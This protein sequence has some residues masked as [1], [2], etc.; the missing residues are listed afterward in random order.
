[1]VL[2][3]LHP[4]NADTM[5]WSAYISRF[6]QFVVLNGIA[7]DL[8]VP[9]LISTV[10]DP[11]YG[12]MYN[13]C[14]PTD[15]GTKTLEQLVRLISNYLHPCSNELEN[16]HKFRSRKQKASESITDYLHELKQMANSCYFKSK[17]MENI[18][19]QLVSGLIDKEIQKRIFDKGLRVYQEILDLALMLEAK[20]IAPI[21]KLYDST[22]E[23]SNEG[24]E[25]DTSVLAD[26]PDSL[27]PEH[28]SSI[29][30]AENITLNMFFQHVDN[31]QQSSL[32]QKMDASDV[33]YDLIGVTELKSENTQELEQI[34]ENWTVFRRIHREHRNRTVT[35]AV[36]PGV[37]VTRRTDLESDHGED[38]W[39]SFTSGGRLVYVGLVYVSFNHDDECA[40]RWCEN[41]QNF[42]ETLK[43]TV[44]ILGNIIQLTYSKE[45][46]YFLKFTK[47]FC[48]F[49]RSCNLSNRISSSEHD[50]LLL[51][52]DVFA[53]VSITEGLND[54][55]SL[56]FNIKIKILE[57]PSTVE[58]GVKELDKNVEDHKNVDE[59]ENLPGTM[60]SPSQP[61]EEKRTFNMFFQHIEE[62]QTLT[63][64]MENN[65]LSF[66]NNDFIGLTGLPHN[67]S[68]DV[69][70]Y[71]EN[72]TVIKRV[73][74]QYHSKV[75]L[76]IR[77]GINFTRR[78]DLESSN[79]EDIW[80]SFTSAG[81][82]VYV[83]VV[84]CFYNKD[85][86][87]WCKKLENYIGTLKDTVIVL[88]SMPL[89]ADDE[90]TM[91]T[92]NKFLK[93]CGFIDANGFSHYNILLLQNNVFSTVCAVEDIFKPV[94]ELPPIN[95]KVWL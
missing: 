27:V 30:P 88:G 75:K 23:T 40:K 81:R 86:E 49:L 46:D 6:K 1:M 32:Q 45:W 20:S 90:G 55:P 29:P 38:V 21:E 44:I 43:G 82:H 66:L 63:S 26:P 80:V 9:L 71:I 57:L 41:V 19:D 34:T 10:G 56:P 13:L 53:S 93:N 5:E 92:Y 11:I 83:C 50:V 37:D 31:F 91:A 14:A 77:T 33:N 17:I 16:R 42:I 28:E 74:E 79:G 60:T 84:N 3:N 47:E 52:E 62:L 51:K 39:V 25:C 64:L 36:R 12:L 8:C 70:E 48:S 69:V 67:H 61:V 95:V 2:A 15:P 35:L 59:L 7:D 78:T 87:T 73:H 18:R 85:V 22:E 24:K 65:D 89:I 72:W 4:F 54:Y 58:G 76:A 68:Q 94:A